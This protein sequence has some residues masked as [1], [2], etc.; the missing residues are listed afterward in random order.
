M[1][2][3]AQVIGRRNAMELAVPRRQSHDIG[4]VIVDPNSNALIDGVEIEPFIQWPDDRGAFA[5]LFRFGTGG[6]ARDFVSSE[7]NHIQVSAASSY[8]GTIKAI[9]YHFEQTD[10]WVPA[11]GM[12]QVFLCD[13]RSDSRT[14]GDVNTLYIGHLR[15]WKIRIP[16]G[17][18]H[19]YKILGLQPAV[20]V[21]ATNR[22]YNAADEGRLPYNDP[23]INYDWELQHK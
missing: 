14:F 12:L 9:H 20:L 8:P 15:P 13:L 18:G 10:L 16:P 6:I 4:N 19:G 21:Y 11:A 5:E 23:D 7:E 2:N 1:M 17:V 3:R 22:F